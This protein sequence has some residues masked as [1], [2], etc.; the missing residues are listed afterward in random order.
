MLAVVTEVIAI[1]KL[2]H[3]SHKMAAL[4][5]KET[6]ELGLHNLLDK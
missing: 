2:L 3:L 4:F 5:I 1:M 6:H